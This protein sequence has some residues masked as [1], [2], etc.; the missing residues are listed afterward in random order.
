MEVHMQ[1]EPV[2]ELLNRSAER[3]AM[4]RLLGNLRSP[5]DPT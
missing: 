2:P 1:S 3:A 5:A 4:D